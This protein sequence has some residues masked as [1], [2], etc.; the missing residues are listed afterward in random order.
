M[1]KTIRVVIADDHSL[2]RRGIRSILEKSGWIEVVGEARDGEEALALV[3]QLHPDV[4]VLD[5][6]MPRLNG[7]QVAA[8][9]QKVKSPV[10]ILFVSAYMSQHFTRQVY[11][12]GAAGFVSKDVIPSDLVKVVH[13]IAGLRE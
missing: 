1:K 11:K 10:R 9:L 2:A 4:L 6:E 3:E 13:D 5:Y 7:L 12:V 8:H